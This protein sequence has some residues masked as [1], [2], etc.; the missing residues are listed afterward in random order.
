MRFPILLAVTAFGLMSFVMSIIGLQ[1]G[2]KLGTVVGERGQVLAGI[3]LVR[4]PGAMAAGWLLP[5]QPA[6]WCAVVTWTSLITMM[7]IAKTM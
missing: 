1:L 3:M 7:T 2:T 5:A 4:L 6:Q